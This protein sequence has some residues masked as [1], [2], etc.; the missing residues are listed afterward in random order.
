MNSEQNIE[1]FFN[2]LQVK[3]PEG[4]VRIIH[5]SYEKAPGRGPLTRTFAIDSERGQVQW[6]V[7]VDHAF[8]ADTPIGAR[9][10][11]EMAHLAA[12]ELSSR[13]S[14][15]WIGLAWDQVAACWSFTG[16][17]DASERPAAWA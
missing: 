15:T 16:P 11:D 5:G 7:T 8:F 6:F 12:A 13:P 10:I 9:T 3:F 14:Q 17:V 2:A 1:H 4:G